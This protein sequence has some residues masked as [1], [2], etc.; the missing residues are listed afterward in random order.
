VFHEF[1]LNITDAS[2]ATWPDGAVLDSFVVCAPQR[3]PAKDLA[4]AFEASLIGR[5]AFTAMPSLTLELDN[6]SL[7]WHT[8]VKVGGPDA[9]GALQAVTAAFAAAEVVV[10][11]ARIVTVDGMIADRFAVTDRVG[12]KLD[13]A[14]MERVRTALAKGGRPRRSLRRP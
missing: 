3:P 10:H 5:L 6:E 4:L 8:A 13:D 14:A 7:P 9:T 1:G 11:S 2:I 12:R